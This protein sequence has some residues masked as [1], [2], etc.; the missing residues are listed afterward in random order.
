MYLSGPPNADLGV[1]SGVPSA[2]ETASVCQPFKHQTQE[3]PKL[4]YQ[5]VLCSSVETLAV[6]DQGERGAV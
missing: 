6:F 4:I 1:S 5:P 2:T 3:V